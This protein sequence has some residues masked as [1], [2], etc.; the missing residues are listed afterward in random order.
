MS[1][2]GNQIGTGEPFTWTLCTELITYQVWRVCEREKKKTQLIYKQLVSIQQVTRIQVCRTG[3]DMSVRV[4]V[5]VCVRDLLLMC[6]Q[7]H[8]HTHTQTH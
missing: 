5:R 6:T 8:T 2:K 3:N 7:K 4:R 1:T